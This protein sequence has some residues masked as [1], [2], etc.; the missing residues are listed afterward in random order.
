LWDVERGAQLAVL[1]RAGRNAIFSLTPDSRWLLVGGD[2]LGVSVWDLSNLDEPPKRFRPRTKSPESKVEP[3]AEPTSVAIS[4]DGSLALIG[5]RN[6]VHEMWD[7]QRGEMK[8][9]VFG[10]SE[11]IVACYFLPSNSTGDVRDR[12]AVTASADGTV[13]WW[14]A[15][16]G[17]ESSKERL[18]M[19]AAI[20]IAALSHDGKLLAC[21]G[22]LSKG[23]SKLWMWNLETRKMIATHDLK[24][25]L[26]Q[27]I[28]FDSIEEKT[29][30]VC[31]SD[32]G[33]QKTTNGM[34]QA[35]LP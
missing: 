12:T 33:R 20:H 13:A 22:T 10:H 2:D 24:G 25:V 30:V 5:N 29:I 35:R 19:F 16:T 32:I 26:I 28:T 4:E 3:I 14:D 9:Q 6:G 11:G 7:I 17:K 8:H 23:N 1:E 34:R 18:K 27:E 31:T 21:G 15:N